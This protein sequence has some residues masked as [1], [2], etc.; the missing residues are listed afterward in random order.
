[1]GAHSDEKWEGS[2]GQEVSEGLWDILVPCPAARVAKLL[3]CEVLA[4]LVPPQDLE[5]ECKPWIS[6]YCELIEL[7]FG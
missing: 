2:P 7:V 6:N 4:F 1:M 5:R 3:L